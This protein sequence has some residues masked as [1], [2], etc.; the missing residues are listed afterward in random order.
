[1]NNEEKINFLNEV[2]ED[3]L[4]LQ[5]KDKSSK[6][7]IQK[8]VEMFIRNVYGDSSQYL[9]DLNQIDFI[10]HPGVFF[11]DYDYSKE[12][13]DKWEEGKNLWINLFETM[14]EEIETFS[15][16][17]VIEKSHKISPR[18]KNYNKVFIVHGHDEEMLHATA[19][20]LEKLDLE[21]VVLREQP[22][23]GRTIIEK[24][25]DYSDVDFA[26]VLFSPDDLGRSKTQEEFK[27]RPRQNVVFE[28]GF[29]IGKLSRKNVVVL[30]RTVQG[31]EMLSD[32]QGVLFQP[33]NGGWEY[34]I[35]KELKSVGFT[36]D[37]NLL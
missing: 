14:I 21:S 32:F 31:F 9:R 24:F 25:E 10:Y 36:I 12:D 16:P 20:F 11:S 13:L 33:Y 1:M 35:A 22:N 3:T 4:L 19:R 5:N 15:A 2:I 37:L 29:F 30:H 23:Q 28:L 7:K 27:P 34:M 18:S 17:Q 8:R 6:D 26:I